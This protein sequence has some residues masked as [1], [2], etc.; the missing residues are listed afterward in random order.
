MEREKGGIPLVVNDCVSYLD[1]HGLETEGIFRKSGSTSLIEYYK[2]QFD[3]GALF[4][5]Y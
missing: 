3:Q 2:D 5:L 4:F 1:S